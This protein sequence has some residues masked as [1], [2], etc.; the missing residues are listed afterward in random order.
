MP[1]LG[2]P[3]GLLL[4]GCLLL[5][6]PGAACPAPCECSEPARTVKCVQK[7]L[8]AVPPGIP[9]YT[10]N[11]F[12]TGNRIPRLASRDFQGLPRLVTLSLANNR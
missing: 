5:V 1:R 3:G 10:R 8:S 12:I 11:L 9:A 7:E 2:G 6:P 4:L